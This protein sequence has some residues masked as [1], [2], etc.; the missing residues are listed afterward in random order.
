LRPA[1]L[2][3]AVL[4]ALDARYDRFARSGEGFRQR[5]DQ[6]LTC[7]TRLP[8]A[9]REAIEL[10]YARGLLLKQIALAVGAA[11]EPMKKRVQPARAALAECLSESVGVGDTRGASNAGEATV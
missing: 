8:D 11:E 2:D 3:Q 4:E 6:L 1:A 9:M 7:L 5:A 10:V